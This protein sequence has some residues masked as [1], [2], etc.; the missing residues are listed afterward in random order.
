MADQRCATC[1]HWR[2]PEPG[3]EFGACR[4]IDTRSHER[5]VKPVVSAQAFVDTFDEDADLATLPTFGCVLHEVR[6]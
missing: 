4:R 3:E 1:K 5:G 2:A 6:S